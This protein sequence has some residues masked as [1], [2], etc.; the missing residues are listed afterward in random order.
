MSLPVTKFGPEKPRNSTDSDD[1]PLIQRCSR[2]HN[3]S[4]TSV[5]G[6]DMVMAKE[7]QKLEKILKLEVEA[8]QIESERSRMKDEKRATAKATKQ[9]KRDKGGKKVPV[10]QP[11]GDPD[12]TSASLSSVPNVE[13][14]TPGLL[15]QSNQANSL[16]HGKPRT[17]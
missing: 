8:E 17:F 2:T 9:A 10:L 6:A 15:F 5:F 1:E 4:S 14:D 3:P 7:L 16:R 12:H 11:I 13:Q